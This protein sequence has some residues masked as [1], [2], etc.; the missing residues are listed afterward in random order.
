[1]KFHFLL[2]TAVLV[3]TLPIAPAAA[4]ETNSTDVPA[5]LP[6]EDLETC[7][8]PEP[9]DTH[10]VICS[11]DLDGNY[12]ELVLRS[13]LN[14]T[15]TLTDAG[16]MMESGP[17]NRQTTKLRAGEENTVRIRVTT[18]K[19]FAGVTVDTGAV[20]Y[21]VP[22]ERSNTLIG[23]PWT[24]TDTQMGALGGATSVGLFTVALAWRRLS[25]NEDSPERIA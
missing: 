11:A 16:G 7:Q 22:L 15:V 2:V 14:Q 8:Q 18:H 21:G 5:W 10:T 19:G 20:L 25:G 4:Q 12:A 23:G 24:A 17:I 6:S 9:I 13:D 3:V 1:M